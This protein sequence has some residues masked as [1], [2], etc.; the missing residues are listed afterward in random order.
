[1]QFEEHITNKSMYIPYAVCLWSTISK[2]ETFKKIM[3]E[4][5]QII[6]YNNF[7]LADD[8]VRN[9][10]NMEL[11][12]LII[13]LNNILKPPSF[14]QMNL[15]F[16]FNNVEFYNPSLF[17]IP[18]A[19]YSIKVLFDC[20][21]ISVIIKLWSSILTEKH[22]RINNNSFYKL[23]YFNRKPKFTSI[24]NLRRPYESNFSF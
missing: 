12:H 24:H 4:I 14:S 9:F 7:N 22:V 3:N 16:R 18:C 13:F 21:E 2:I 19:E 6:T 5:H 1:M 20:L 10:R 11:I 23:D 17:E 15:N 8:R